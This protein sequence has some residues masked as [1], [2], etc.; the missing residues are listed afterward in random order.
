MLCSWRSG[1]LAPA[2][3]K[4]GSA[5]VDP[6]VSAPVLDC[7]DP[8][9]PQFPLAGLQ[10]LQSP[11]TEKLSPQLG[12]LGNPVQTFGYQKMLYCELLDRLAP[13]STRMLRLF[14]ELVRLV[15]MLFLI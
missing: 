13:L 4:S 2:A 6:V 7:H 3:T 12:Q 5:L 14:A 15:K 1:G 11:A 9:P 10:Q 8:L